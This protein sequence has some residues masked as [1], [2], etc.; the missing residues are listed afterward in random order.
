[1][2]SFVSEAIR[3]GDEE[4]RAG[5]GGENEEERRGTRR[6]KSLRI[7]KAEYHTTWT[8]FGSRFERCRNQRKEKTR[9]SISIGNSRFAMKSTP[10]ERP[11]DQLV[12]SYRQEKQWI[13]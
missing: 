5:F 8:S 11:K 1:M 10:G 6:R 9:E 7:C 4:E 3:E 12:R 13:K 2:N